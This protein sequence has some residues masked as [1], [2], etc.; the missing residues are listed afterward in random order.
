M[1]DFLEVARLGRKIS[2]KG[3]TYWAGT[4]EGRAIYAFMR[5]G[6]LVLMQ[7]EFGPGG[8]REEQQI[9]AMEIETARQVADAMARD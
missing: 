9:Q 5:D 4:V 6:A 2:R 1:A 8:F 3:T 7:P